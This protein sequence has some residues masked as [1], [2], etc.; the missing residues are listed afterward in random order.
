MINEELTFQR[1]GYYAKDVAHLTTKR[2]VVNC[3]N[4]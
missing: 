3:D 1:F 2:I 4:R